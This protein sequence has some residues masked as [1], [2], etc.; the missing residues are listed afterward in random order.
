MVD[1]SWRPWDS[2][3]AADRDE[4]RCGDPAHR[5]PVPPLSKQRGA[6]CDLDHAG[7]NHHRICIDRD[8]SGCGEGTEEW[9]GRRIEGEFGVD[10]PA[11]GRVESG[12]GH[13]AED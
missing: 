3:G 9:V 7:A 13:P 6:E 11:A 2:D 10:M 12:A 4:Q 5:N 8:R 1:G